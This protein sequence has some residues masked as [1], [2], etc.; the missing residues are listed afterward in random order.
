MGAPDHQ[1]SPRAF[2]GVFL[3]CFVTMAAIPE[4]AFAAGIT[5]HYKFNVCLKSRTNCFI[6]RY[7]LAHSWLINNSDFL[8]ADWTKKR[9]KTLPYKEHCVS[10]RAVSRTSYCSKG[11]RSPPYQSC[12]P[13]QEQYFHPLVTKR[14]KKKK[15][16]LSL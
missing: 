2:L 12:Q 9:D 14:K 10:K 15:K 5:R 16:D 4:H 1:F 11:R 6:F 3:F 13:H 8:F 7:C